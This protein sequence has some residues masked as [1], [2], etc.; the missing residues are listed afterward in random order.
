MGLRQQGPLKSQNI[1]LGRMRNQPRLSCGLCGAVA[2]APCHPN[3][4][5][6]RVGGQPLK[7]LHP[8][9]GRE[10]QRMKGTLR[11]FGDQKPWREQR[12]ADNLNVIAKP[13][14]QQHRK[15]TGLRGG[16]GQQKRGQAGLLGHGA[17]V[18][19]GYPF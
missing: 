15:P 2:D 9:L 14:S 12:C 17:G 19:C 3:S 16:S 8:G 18:T 6:R 4:G 1:A 5:Q 7:P 10:D 13:F 11:D